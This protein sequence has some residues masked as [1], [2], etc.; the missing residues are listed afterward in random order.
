M[1]RMKAALRGETE[2]LLTEI[3]KFSLRWEVQK[4]K[5]IQEADQE[6]LNKNINFIKEKIEEWEELK[7]K[8]ENL[9]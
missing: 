3:E 9:V 8:K 5:D 4:P 2:N 1:E 6:T 7:T